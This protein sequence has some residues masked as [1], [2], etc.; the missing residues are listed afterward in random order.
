MIW[1]LYCGLAAG[2]VLRAGVGQLE[3]ALR[4]WRVTSW[5]DAAMAVPMA[6]A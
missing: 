1:S 2:Q 5:P 4:R 6:A 3:L